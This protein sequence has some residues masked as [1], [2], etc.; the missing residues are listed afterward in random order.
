MLTNNTRCQWTGRWNF[1]FVG[2][3]NPEVV[4]IEG[5]ELEQ[6][7]ERDTVY[8]CLGETT[9]YTW[10]IDEHNLTPITEEQN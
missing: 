6:S 8:K 5:L 1:G 7:E 3:T 4:V 10:Y 9:N 2:Q